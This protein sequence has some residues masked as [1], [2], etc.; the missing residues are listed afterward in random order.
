MNRPLYVW[1]I[2]AGSVAAVLAG[3]FA[4][5]QAALD[6]ERAQ[7]A[8]R[9]EAA[10]EEAVR[11]A[12]WRMDSALAPIVGTEYAWPF[13]TSPTD[14]DR[15]PGPPP[16]PLAPYVRARFLLTPGGDV[17]FL[18]ADSEGAIAAFRESIDPAVLRAALE[19]T[20]ESEWLYA[21]G[22][23]T[24]DR[25]AR[26][27]RSRSRTLSQTVTVT[28]SNNAS[29]YTNARPSATNPPLV[30]PGMVP[31]W[32]DGTLVLARHTTVGGADAVQGSW[33]DWPALRRSLLSSVSDLLPH[34][35]LMPAQGADLD[36]GRLLAA[37][38]LRLVPGDVA[39]PPP[40]ASPV[41]LALATAWVCCL[42]AVVAVG[43]LLG[44]ALSL[45]ER[46]ATFVSA[47]THEMRTPLTT[48]RLY[49]DML[50]E[51]MV[52]DDAKRQRYYETLRAEAER[53]GHLVENVL[54]FARLER[55][56]PPKRVEPRPLREALNGA[57]ESLRLRAELAGRALVVEEDQSGAMDRAVR[58]DAAALER[59]LMN[60]V[61][62][63]C[64]HGRPAADPVIR[65]SVSTNCENVRIRVRDKGPGI[66]A[67][68][69]R[70]LF[71]PFGRSADQA[72]AAA[73][74]VGLGLALSRRLA[75]RLG[76]DLQ[77]DGSEPPG[78]CFVLT[79]PLDKVP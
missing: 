79:L 62:N 22:L 70:R 37:L 50:A 71:R 3:L 48:F 25:D 30:E 10:V 33:L 11:L 35:D 18:G 73:P 41:G 64:K 36:R 16:I 14:S 21:Q 13:L 52:P 28:R 55:G 49:S 54:A 76:G 44:L 32:V 9:R 5:T 6:L 31:L 7:S 17:R 51:G 39:L 23:L 42:L 34:A 56:R 26:E 43:I 68:H 27:W 38:P 61:D 12:L 69:A 15:E 60:L 75:R 20:R 24:G 8:M 77:L 66:S 72:A 47:V 1:A 45:S 29:L 57:A 19:E 78:A 58:A 67:D 2:F 65:L 40:P 59:I 53:L 4:I 46:R 74:G 63:A